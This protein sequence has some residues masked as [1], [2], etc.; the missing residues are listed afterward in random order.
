M[1]TRTA[2][3]SCHTNPA[4]AAAGCAAAEALLLLGQLSGGA[5]AAASPWPA[6][7]ADGYA[8]LAAAEQAAARASIA[9]LPSDADFV[10]ALTALGCCAE[11]AGAWGIGRGAA[12]RQGAAAA[13]GGQGLIAQAQPLP[14]AHNL[15]LLLQLLVRLCRL[16]GAGRLPL[17]LALGVGGQGQALARLLLALQLDEAVCLVAKGSLEDACASLL[18]AAGEVEWSRL[19]PALLEALAGGLGPSARCGGGMHTLEASCCDAAFGDAGRQ[20]S[21]CAEAAAC[22]CCCCCEGRACCCCRSC[23][24]RRVA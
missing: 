13:A 24:C 18:E 15:R 12:G 17:P 2:C 3:A 19:A 23:R 20:V 1:P 8:P 5:D 4:A 10:G 7:A 21:S 9:W 11:H 22:C 6:S 14:H 16:A